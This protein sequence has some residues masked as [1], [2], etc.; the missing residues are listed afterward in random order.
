MIVGISVAAVAVVVLAGPS[1]LSPLNTQCLRR[2]E[3]PEI[4][5]TVGAFHVCKPTAQEEAPQCCCS[6]MEPA[7]CT[8]SECKVTLAQDACCVARH[9]FVFVLAAAADAEVRR[10]KCGCREN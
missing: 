9:C 5:P 8:R 6:H 10:G 1:L 7:V 2:A 3:T 4:H